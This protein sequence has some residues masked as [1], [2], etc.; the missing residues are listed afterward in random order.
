MNIL[1]LNTTFQCGGA[2]KVTSQIFQGMHARGHEV[3]QIVSYDTRHSVLP[4]GVHVLYDSFFMRMFNRLIS[5]NR[6][7]TSLHISY[8]RQYILHFLKKHKID[9]IHLHNPHDSFL[10]IEDI[11]DLSRVCPVVWTL[12]DFWAM[13]G[14]CTYP[15]GCDDRWKSGC[16]TC[17]R[18]GNYPAIRKDVAHTLWEAKKKAF[19]DARITFTV[20][21]DWMLTQFNC[22]YL[23]G[24]PCERIYNSLD[25]TIWK[26]LDK[27]ALLARH[28]IDP[29]T[30]ILAF[31][32]ADPG[33]EL[34]GMDYLLKALSL[35]P[36][37]ESYLLLI[38]GKDHPGLHTLN[39][40]FQIRHWGYLNSQEQ[41]NEFYS[42]ADLLVI[43]LAPVKDP[44]AQVPRG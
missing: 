29:K 8:S 15:H 21:S 10:G 31:I 36:D 24:K 30:K 32:A 1:Y 27:A 12:H 43:S 44:Q 18:L 6:S 22:S 35:L 42:L 4:E 2:E 5:G 34:K 19:A 9:L 17:E 3:Y 28:K 13:T 14:H 37:P 7:N 33:K 11:A 38:A 41:L 25:T 39:T 40:K 23:A 26:P 20:P 16:N